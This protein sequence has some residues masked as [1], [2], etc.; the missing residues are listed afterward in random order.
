M[1]GWL[2]LQEDR[3]TVSEPS[4]C[5]GEH[6]GWLPAVTRYDLVASSAESL[7]EL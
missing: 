1:A 5:R 7:G 4:R 6:N 3:S 2:Q